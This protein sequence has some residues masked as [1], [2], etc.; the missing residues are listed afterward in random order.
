MLITIRNPMEQS[1]RKSRFM[2]KNARL[3]CFVICATGVALWIPTLPVQ[4]GSKPAQHVRLGTDVLL[5]KGT[6]TGHLLDSHGKPLDGAVVKV[7]KDGK[8][9]AQTV[10]TADGTYTIGGLTPGLHTISMADGQFPVRLW[11]PKAAPTSAK[12][13]LTVSK[14]AIRGQLLGSGGATLGS[15]ATVG[16][17][18]VAVV[19]GSI[20]VT[21]SQEI[22]DL[23]DE[24]DQL[25]TP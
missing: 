10:T 2:H 25:Q 4:A 5:V 1:E 20:A 6:L 15:F 21:Q 7:A 9:I 16:A 19:A 14:T 8:Q 12:T 11:S 13:Q 24:I 17:L 3:T 18:G 23:Q 22:N